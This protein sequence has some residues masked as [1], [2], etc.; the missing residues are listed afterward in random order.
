M[1]S[2]QAAALSY[3]SID[4]EPYFIV[5]KVRLVGYRVHAPIKGIE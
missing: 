3:V 5:S 1:S 4:Q 2:F